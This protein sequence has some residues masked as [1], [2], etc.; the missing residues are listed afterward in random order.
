MVVENAPWQYLL[1]CDAT[2]HHGDI[3]A[4]VSGAAWSDLI[5]I[6]VEEKREID[7]PAD[8]VWE[9]IRHFDRVLTWI[10]GGD[11]STIRVRGS[12]IGAIRDIVLSTQGY[13]QHRL[14]AYDD[15][16][17]MFSYALTAGKPIGMQDY[18]VV[19]TV[20]PNGDGR[21]TLRW[22]GRMT[23]DSTLNEVEI[24]DALKVALGNMTTGII[25]KLKGRRPE[26]VSQP[27]EDWQLRQ[28]TPRA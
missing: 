3:V 12:G 5:M 11:T 9:E 24:G 23:P 21:C 28:S 22:S 10:P 16:T 26:F 6:E 13:V 18:V 1:Q 27:N 17:R 2:L 14:V 15:S 20:T 19:A 25:A 4:A 7:L 8:V